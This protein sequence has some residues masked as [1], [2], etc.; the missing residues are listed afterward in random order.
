MRKRT[1]REN[2]GNDD[3]FATRA[4]ESKRRFSRDRY[5]PRCVSDW[6]KNEPCAHQIRTCDADVCVLIH[7]K[8]DCITQGENQQCHSSRDTVDISTGSSSHPT[9]L[10]LKQSTNIDA[11]ASVAFLRFL[12]TGIVGTMDK[13]VDC[14]SKHDT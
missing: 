4:R 2:S 12:L 13:N 9:R 6:R 14:V 5:A 3:A 10:D 1:K 7:Q 11:D 8:L